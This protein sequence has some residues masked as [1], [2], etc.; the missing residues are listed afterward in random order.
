MQIALTD[1]SRLAIVVVLT[2]VSLLQQQAVHRSC[3]KN[4]V[5]LNAITAIMVI[6]TVMTLLDARSESGTGV[7]PAR[8]PVL[9]PLTSSPWPSHDHPLTLFSIIILIVT[10][11]VVKKLRLLLSW[12]SR[13]RQRMA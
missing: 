4:A 6:I 10:P 9:P 2:V 1:S 12:T 8:L 13:M 5:L 11:L 7:C 3:E